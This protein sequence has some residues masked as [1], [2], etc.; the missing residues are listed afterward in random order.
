M[1]N[2]GLFNAENAEIRRERRGTKSVLCVESVEPSS[3][4]VS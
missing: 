3:G 4:A 1:T 2:D